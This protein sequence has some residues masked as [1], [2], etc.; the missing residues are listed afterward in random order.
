MCLIKLVNNV[1]KTR[2]VSK[3]DSHKRHMLCY[4]NSIIKLLEMH[5]HH[6]IISHKRGPPPPLF[7]KI[8]LKYVNVIKL[9]IY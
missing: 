2:I 7:V 9:N 8:S 5:I 4:V 1:K 3:T 6:Y